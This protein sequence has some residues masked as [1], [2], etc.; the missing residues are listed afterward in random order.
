MYPTD[1]SEPLF[2]MP[3]EDSWNPLEHR[4]PRY[5]PAYTAFAP[6]SP[7]L[8]TLEDAVSSS[9]SPMARSKTFSS[10]AHSTNTSTKSMKAKGISWQHTVVMKGGVQSVLELAEEK[11]SKRPR[12]VGVRKGALDPKA[13]EKA[14]RVRRMKA[15]WGCWI[16]KVPVSDQNRHSYAS[17]LF[18]SGEDGLAN[19]DE[20][21]QLTLE[22]NSAQKAIHVCDAENFIPSACLQLTSC[23]QEWG[24]LTMKTCSFQVH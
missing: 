9:K 3:T 1:A 7:P 22:I 14:R 4:V 10:K 21:Y 15:C 6:S 16:L 2:K 11:P 24:L 5:T 19:L 18:I 20:I 8:N 12:A 23:A 17:E 13:K